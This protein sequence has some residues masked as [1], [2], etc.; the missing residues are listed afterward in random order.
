MI[1]T[2]PVSPLSYIPEHEAITECPCGHLLNLNETPSECPECGMLTDD[3]GYYDETSL[4]PE[5]EL[6]FE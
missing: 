2:N 3:I 4:A 5:K 1:Y 6:C